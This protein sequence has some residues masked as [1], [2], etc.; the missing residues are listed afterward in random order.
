VKLVAWPLALTLPFAA[1]RFGF[2]PHQSPDATVDTPADAPLPLLPCGSPSQ[3]A[4]TMPSAVAGSGSANMDEPVPVIAATATDAGYYV[5]AVG[6]TGG[7]HGFSYLFHDGVVAPAVVDAPVFS[8]ATG[9]LAAIPTS[10]GVI[11]SIV[12]GRPDAIGTAL[13]PLDASLAAHGQPQRYQAWFGS[14][15]TIAR[16]SD[17]TLAFLGT[18]TDVAAKLVATDGTARGAEHTVIDRSD[19]ANAPTITA[20]NTGF[21][22]TWTATSVSP[23]EV[24]ARL[25]DKQLAAPNPQPTAINTAAM[26]NGQTP[27]ASYAA[28]PDRYLFAW[29]FK[30]GMSNDEVW[31]SLR[32]SALSEIRAVQLTKRGKFPK[33]VAGAKDFLV[34]WQDLDSTSQLGAAR[35]NF[36]ASIVPLT[37]S[38]GGGASLVW[39]VVSRAGQHALIWVESGASTRVWLDPLCD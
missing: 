25:V 29:W 9:T 20:S 31:V 38:G 4:F 26:F 16:A 19:S 7:V 14:D 13:V 11:A 32:D 17:G 22:V 35:V 1:C 8:G 36:D 3:F 12:Y 18:T 30:D 15:A 34:V 33:V 5:L 28:G 27:R 23:H 2:E 10:D 37:V 6:P 24:R 21:I 39:D